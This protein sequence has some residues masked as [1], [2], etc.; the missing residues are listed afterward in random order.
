MMK[1]KSILAF[2]ALLVLAPFMT[3]FGRGSG[4][5][6]KSKA[7]ACTNPHPEQLCTA[8]NTFAAGGPEA[9]L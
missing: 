3:L 9:E 7:T 1:K 5:D 4:N 6:K 2:L 8:A